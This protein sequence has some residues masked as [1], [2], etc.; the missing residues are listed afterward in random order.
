MFGHRMTYADATE[1]CECLEGNLVIVNDASEQLLVGG[2]HE[3]KRMHL[4]LLGEA[5]AYYRFWMGLSNPSGERTAESWKWADGSSIT[6]K[7]W[8][9][10]QP[11]YL[12]NGTIP[13]ECG[14]IDAHYTECDGVKVRK[15]IAW[16]D[17]S[18]YIQHSF[19]C[20]RINA[21]RLE[22][23][24]DK[25]EFLYVAPLDR[26]Y[27]LLKDKTYSFSSAKSACEFMGG[28][29][30]IFRNRVEED[31]VYGALA[32]VLP[33]FTTAPV[34]IGLE[35]EEAECGISCGCCGS[36]DCG[37][38]CDKES[39]GECEKQM[40]DFNWVSGRPLGNYMNWMGQ[41]CGS[42]VEECLPE[43]LCVLTWVQKTPDTITGAWTPVQDCGMMAH[44]ICEIQ[45]V[46][47]S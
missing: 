10:D 2:A 31:L 37:C 5:G 30:V 21:P 15:Y 23:V 39:S 13:E 47:Y 34:W 9:W 20:E 25:V 6:Y 40:G 19:M 14:L 32:T 1:V 42:I 28:Q 44:A 16:E 41:P 24:E 43:G 7:N 29:M 46:Y 22:D 8:R 33:E 45:G 17:D 3:L 27:V 26:S 4:A 36:A 38:S 18:C 11:T 12:L 35:R